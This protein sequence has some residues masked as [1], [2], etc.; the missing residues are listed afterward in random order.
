M[1]VN[2]IDDVKTSS[3]SSSLPNVNYTPLGQFPRLT[4]DEIMPE[5]DNSLKF[6]ALVRTFYNYLQKK[7]II[8]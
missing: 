6:L 7:I 1:D 2:L 3:L 5:I 4:L 8:D